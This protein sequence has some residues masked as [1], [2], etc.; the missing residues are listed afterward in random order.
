MEENKKSGFTRTA[1]R[2]QAFC[3][4][5]GYSISKP[6]DTELSEYFETAVKINGYGDGP[7]LQSVFYGVI[8]E[9]DR[10]DNIIE[11]YSVGWKKE[12]I[13]AV[14]LTLM[15]ICLYESKFLDDVPAAVA[16]NEAV[17]LAKKYDTEKAPAFINGILNSA[18]KGEGLI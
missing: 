4:L 6:D 2:E 10:L 16:I 17:E 14:S 18:L 1:L 5:F 7:Y 15:R 11:K 9:A 13:S 12:R 3:L 8:K